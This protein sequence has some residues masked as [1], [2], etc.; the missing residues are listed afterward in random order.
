MSVPSGVTKLANKS[1]R[2]LISLSDDLAISWLFMANCSL[3]RITWHLWNYLDWI[4][5]TVLI[6][7]TLVI[8][9][10]IANVNRSIRPAIKVC[11]NIDSIFSGEYTIYGY[12]SAIRCF[13]IILIEVVDSNYWWCFPD[14]VIAIPTKKIDHN[15]LHIASTL[16]GYFKLNKLNECCRVSKPLARK[17][18]RALATFSCETHEILPHEFY[19]VAEPSCTIIIFSLYK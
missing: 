6:P 3:W 5:N 18:S 19:L 9:S 10:K 16:Y 17:L 14:S 15:Q 13:F 7:A 11:Y 2:R 4:Y 8:F 12:K 1:I